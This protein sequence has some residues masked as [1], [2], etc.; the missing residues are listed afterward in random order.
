MGP[1]VLVPESALYRIFGIFAQ[2]QKCQEQGLCRDKMSGPNGCCCS[3]MSCVSVVI[4]M[5][6]WHPL[7]SLYPNIPCGF[8]RSSWLRKPDQGDKLK[9]SRFPETRITLSRL[10][11][12]VPVL[13]IVAV[14]RWQHRELSA[15]QRPSLGDP[16][17]WEA[18]WSEQG[19]ARGR[20]G[21]ARNV[22]HARCPAPTNDS[23]YLLSP[24]HWDCSLNKQN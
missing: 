22:S 9:W 14:K 8:W 10:A 12:L 19:L 7:C 3:L 20:A 1:G 5:I 23:K 21:N 15:N 13:W 11:S 6:P 4:I 17:Q 16:D 18:S 24:P 2:V